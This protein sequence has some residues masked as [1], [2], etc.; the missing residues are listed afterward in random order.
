MVKRILGVLTIILL[1]VIFVSRE[2]DEVLLEES[3]VSLSLK[4]TDEYP[5]FGI[6]GAGCEIP[7]EYP[8]TLPGAAE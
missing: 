3:M 6:K 2:T 1:I 7:T 4:L 5:I 8:E